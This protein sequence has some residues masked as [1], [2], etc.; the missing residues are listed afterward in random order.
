MSEDQLKP[1]DSLFLVDNYM[2]HDPS[3]SVKE[4]L[5]DNLHHASEGKLHVLFSSNSKNTPLKIFAK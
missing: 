1:F 4:L 5:S 3:F 2:Y